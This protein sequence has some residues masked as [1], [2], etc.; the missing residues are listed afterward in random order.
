M[1]EGARLTKDC[2]TTVELYHIRL[3]QDL[4]LVTTSESSFYI[5]LSL[6]LQH[7]LT[8]NYILVFART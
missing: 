7:S 5:R 3:I 2:T 8:E 4:L 1:E 6:T